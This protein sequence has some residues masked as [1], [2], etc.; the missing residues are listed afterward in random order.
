M[1]LR[2]RQARKRQRRAWIQTGCLL[3]LR[4]RFIK[5]LIVFAQ[6]I[7]SP[8]IERCRLWERE[9]PRP[10]RRANAKRP[11]L[12]PASASGMLPTVAGEYRPESCR[13]GTC[14]LRSITDAWSVS[15]SPSRCTLVCKAWVACRTWLACS[16]V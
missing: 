2:F 8:I 5:A 1:D 13:T 4:Y 7:Q 9:S 3:K 10:H 12:A 14:V 6:K 16:G 11:K 15:S